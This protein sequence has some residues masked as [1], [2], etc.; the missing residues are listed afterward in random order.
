M[1]LTV[2]LLWTSGWKF[3]GLAVQ[4]ITA[5][6]CYKVQDKSPCNTSEQM[7]QPESQQFWPTLWR[8]PSLFH[9]LPHTTHSLSIYGSLV[10]GGRNFLRSRTAL[11][12][13]KM[14]QLPETHAALW[15]H[16]ASA[17][18]PWINLRLFHVVSA[19]QNREISILRDYESCTEE[20]LLANKHKS[21]HL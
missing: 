15:P 2:L 20:K 19:F 17:L 1:Q 4:P 3:F 14:K 6:P 18:F 7:L 8:D 5:R 13:E 10:Y 16:W 11:H 9:L 12:A 21:T